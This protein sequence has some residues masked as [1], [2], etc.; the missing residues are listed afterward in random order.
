MKE[1]LMTQKV[2]VRYCIELAKGIF[3]LSL[4]F[5]SPEI[6]QPGQFVSLTPL[7]DS[8]AP[9]PFSVAG[10]NKTKWAESFSIIFRVVGKNTLAYSKLQCGDSIEIHGPKG[11]PIFFDERKYILVAGGMGIGGIYYP[12]Q[13]LIE[14]ANPPLVLYGIKSANE[15]FDLHLSCQTITTVEERDNKLVTDLLEERLKS[16]GGNSVVIACGPVGML[17]KVASLSSKYGNDCRVIVEEMMACGSGSCKSCAV[18]MTKGLP[19]YVCHDGP[20]F[21]AAEIDW[22]K[23]PYRFPAYTFV[24]KCRDIVIKDSLEIVLNGQDGRTLI[25]KAPIL[26]AS[27]CFDAVK[28]EDLDTSQ[29]GGLVTKGI[30]ETERAG[31]NCP[32]VSE[33]SGGMRNAI[34]LFGVGIDSFIKDELPIWTKLGKPVLVNIAGDTIEE[35]H[36]LSEKLNDTSVAGQEINV[37]C[38]NV[39]KGGMLFGLSPTET[40]KIVQGVRKKAPKQFVLLKVTPFAGPIMLEVIKAGIDEGA[41]A[42]VIANTLPSFDVDVR[43]HRPTLGS[44]NGAGGYSGSGILPYVLFLVKLVYEVDWLRIPIVGVGG[45]SCGED[46]EKMLITGASAVEVGTASFRNKYIFTDVCDFLHQEMEKKGIPW[47]GDLVGTLVR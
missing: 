27:G 5:L 46:A 26:N 43:T 16:N 15:M 28:D 44:L 47:I 20:S 19:K 3:R 1:R 35:Y 7:S 29:V 38:P 4:S 6:F 2:R 23:M 25:L 45:I 9:R 12:A 24:E 34:G 8:C 42:V 18:F 37:S 40:A 30:Y 11:Q 39:L 36:R 41:D 32:R 17:S 14:E 10:I 33:V 22:N 13:K 21:N 31:N